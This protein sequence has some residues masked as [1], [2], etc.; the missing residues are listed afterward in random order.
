MG[1]DIRLNQRLDLQLKLAPQIIQSI[2][3]LQL[4]AM[5]LLDVIEQELDTNEFL[6]KT[7]SERL[8]D[9]ESSSNG[10]DAE[11]K[12]GSEDGLKEDELERYEQM[13]IWDDP[14]LRRPRSRDEG[15][16]NAKMEAMQNTAST[17]PSLQDELT[18]QYLL[19]DVDERFQQLAEQIIFNI[20]AEG[21]LAYP[22][23]EILEPAW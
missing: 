22:L 23:E 11:V 17:G 3:L 2:E 20:N 14:S 12:E 8:A 9:E 18:A 7:P 21:Y 5:D 10:T 6:E 13:D 16:L 19:L 1:L 15:L 4:P